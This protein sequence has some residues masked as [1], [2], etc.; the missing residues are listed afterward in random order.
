MMI[1]V[2]LIVS[3]NPR[4]PRHS[5]PRISTRIFQFIIV[6]M[7]W[8]ESKDFLKF[9]FEVMVLPSIMIPEV[10]VLFVKLV[11]DLIMIT[12][13]WVVSVSNRP[14]SSVIVVVMMPV[15]MPK[16]IIKGIEVIQVM[17]CPVVSEINVVVIIIREYFVN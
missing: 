15:V 16:R 17:V 8:G 9:V 4:M 12:V 10:P 6:P 3:I 7:V 5:I 14:E 11:V 1:N 13:L 2:E